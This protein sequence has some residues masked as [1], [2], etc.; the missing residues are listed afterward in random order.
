MTDKA[1]ANEW[2][3]DGDW[4]DL[5]EHDTPM[6]LY[7][8]QALG[9]LNLY[10]EPLFKGHSRGD[11][12]ESNYRSLLRQLADELDS[13]DVLALAKAGRLLRLVEREKDPVE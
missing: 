7:L 12:M 6:A 1:K 8:R 10:P 2:F 9:K 3:H 11:E 5:F 13:D 4:R